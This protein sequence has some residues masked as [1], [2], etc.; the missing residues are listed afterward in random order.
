MKYS[1]YFFDLDGTLTD[2]GEGIMNAVKHSLQKSGDE[3]PPEE[4]LI[5]FIGPPLWES[6]ENFCGFSKEKAYMAVRYY[7]EY[8]NEKGWCENRVYDGIP[9]LLQRL[10]DSGKRLAVATS[11]PEFFALRILE[12]FDLLKYFDCVTSSNLNGTMVEKSEIVACTLEKCGVIDKSSAV[13]IGDRMHD[14]IGAHTNGLKCVY[15]LYGFGNYVEAREYEAEY[16]VRSPGEI[17][18]I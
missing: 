11:K 8:Y 5:K 2:S 3:I 15:V 4:T 14:V 9:A 17:A 16:I 12:H 18:D 13:M 7:R 10:K 6:F 1:T